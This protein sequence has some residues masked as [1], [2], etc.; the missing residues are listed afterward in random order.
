MNAVTKMKEIKLDSSNRLIIELRHRID[1]LEQKRLKINNEDN[2]V[3][4]IKKRTREL[5]EVSTTHG[6]PNIVRAKNL[7]IFMVWIIVTFISTCAGS[8][9][10]I[11]NI[12]DFL[13]YN[14]VTSL[15]TI[16]EQQSQF[17]TI[18]ICAYPSLNMKI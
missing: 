9:F 3:K 14:T 4:K 11:D 7:T 15:E 6:L 13:K 8:Y 12:I 17:P 18:S 5:L 1:K 10:L 2:K 16:N